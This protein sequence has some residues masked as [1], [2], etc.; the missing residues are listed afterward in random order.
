MVRDAFTGKAEGTVKSYAY[1]CRH[2][3]RWLHL[4]Q[5]SV[6]F[7]I[8]D[9]ILAKYLCDLKSRASSDSVVTSAAAAIKWI[10]AL[11][12]TNRNPVDSP[13]V[14]Q[15]ISGAKRS[16]HKPP[17]QKCPLTLSQLHLILD[18][19]AQHDCTTLQLRTACY[20][21]L[22]YALLFRHNEIADLKA[23]HIFALPDNQGLRIF[24]PK[25]KTDVF[26]DGDFG[27]IADTQDSYSP[28]KILKKFLDRLG[29]SIGEDKFVFTPLTFCAKTK[30]YKPTRDKPLSYTR[31]REL[32]LEALRSIGVEDVTNY[33]LH[34]LRSGGATHLTNQG[35]SE[36]LI[37][38]HGRWK[39][40]TAKNRYI[41]R[42]APQRLSVA[43]AVMMEF[44]NY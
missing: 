38:Q 2:F 36:E 29:I 3:I 14:Q 17:S 12:N 35:V 43:K 23:N 5:C 34:S 7:P 40:T 6:I 41:Q 22:K 13:V 32:F 42:D 30:T 21:A 8:D 19:F 44:N 27:Y 39:T 31:C 28:V 20:V 24:I 10:H 37:L 18:V 9:E 15:I 25:S 26:R 1:R 16:L 33:G 4:H 11:S